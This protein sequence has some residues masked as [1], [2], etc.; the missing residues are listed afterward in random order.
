[1]KSA[2]YFLLIIF[3][4]LT[5][6]FAG[7]VTPPEETA[8][9]EEAAAAEAE[10]EPAP[11]P[12]EET[13]A[14]PEEIVRTV[15]LLTKESSYFADGVLDEYTSYVYEEEG[16]KLITK[17][18]YSD[19]GSLIE[20]R[21][22]TYGNGLPV[23]EEVFN[24]SGE[25]QTYY[26]YE[27]DDSGKLISEASY[28]S[29]DELQLKSIY[30][31]NSEGEKVKWSIYSGSEALFSYTEYSYEDGQFVR[32][33]TYTP[34]GELDVYFENDYNDAGNMTK[35]T[36]Y[37]ADGD[38]LEFRTYEYKNGSMVREIIHRANGSVQRT[39][40]YSND[41]RGNPLEI[42]YKNA[43]GKVQERLTREYMQREY[44]EYI[45]E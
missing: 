10:P 31:Y 12:E 26:V 29:E 3:S 13:S 32:A 11:E 33:E 38:V 7:C 17:E 15:D 1:M 44:I 23:K 28:D 6:L 40:E 21:V 25:L 14:E 34:G 16:E 41:E 4:A 2:V 8:E 27:Y 9:K 36:Q 45:E 30:E 39:V 37:D 5:L 22:F 20:K 42:I 35:S 43:S 24:E 19:D 18:I